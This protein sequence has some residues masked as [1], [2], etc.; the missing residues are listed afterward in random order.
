MVYGCTVLRN[1]IVFFG[2]FNEKTTLILE[3]EEEGSLNIVAQHSSIDYCS[4]YDASFKLVGDKL[5]SF[6]KNK[7]NEVHVLEAGE[8]K[9]SQ[10][11][12]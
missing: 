11:S 3:E 7:Y 10:H 12:P 2:S 1:K 5:Y 6:S 4:A 9:W 8:G